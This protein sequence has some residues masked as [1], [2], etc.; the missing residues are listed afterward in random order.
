M[1]LHIC[2]CMIRCVCVFMHLCQSLCVCWY[3]LVGFPPGFASH[4]MLCECVCVLHM[5]VCCSFSTHQPLSGK[6]PYT[7]LHY[8]PHC[9]EEGNRGG[10][11][12]NC[13]NCNFKL[14]STVQWF[15]RI[16]TPAHV[17]VCVFTVVCVLLALPVGAVCRNRIML[18][19]SHICV[20]ECK[21]HTFGSLTAV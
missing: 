20:C 2:S 10:L 13:I 12:S 5:S 15:S 11:S 21:V 7:P 18:F 14:K 3:A 8:C 17:F 16:A 9:G 1:C 6:V 19:T 4:I